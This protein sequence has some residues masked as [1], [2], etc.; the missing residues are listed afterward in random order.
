[1][2]NEQYNMY[3]TNYSDIGSNYIETNS[4]GRRTSYSIR[5]KVNNTTLT[6]L[7]TISKAN[8]KYL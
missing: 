2:I 5:N 3:N 8:N 4:L 6:D 7:T 1:M